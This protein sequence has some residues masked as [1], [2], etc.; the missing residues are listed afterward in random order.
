ME[1]ERRAIQSDESQLTRNL[2][3]A[4]YFTKPTLEKPHR[5]LTLMA[6][7]KA[8][9]KNGNY[10]LAA[11]FADRVLANSSAGKNAD[12]VWPPQTLPPTLSV[13]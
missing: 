7:M 2:E 12:A 1:I 13:C 8:Q 3:L 6:A 5:Q 4:A 11:H 9:F 10:V